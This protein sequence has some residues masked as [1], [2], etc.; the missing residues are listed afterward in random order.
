MA[1]FFVAILLLLG[2]LL[3]S[4]PANTAASVQPPQKD[5]EQAYAER[6]VIECHRRGGVERLDPISGPLGCDFPVPRPSR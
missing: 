6:K 4:A 1:G 3:I 5:P 2:W